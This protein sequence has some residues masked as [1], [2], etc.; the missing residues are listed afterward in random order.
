MI[1][2]SVAFGFTV[3]KEGLLY[4]EK[5][6]D[7]PARVIWRKKMRL[8]TRTSCCKLGDPQAANTATA[9]RS[10]CAIG[11]EG[12]GIDFSLLWGTGNEHILKEA[13]VIP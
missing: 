5:H 6:A 2:S 10:T 7:E 1:D 4:I 12:W 8:R 13:K 3:R 11:V 9:P